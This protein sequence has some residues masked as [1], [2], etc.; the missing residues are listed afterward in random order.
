MAQAG[1]PPGALLACHTRIHKVAFTES[2]GTGKRTQEM[3]ARSNLKQV[4]LELGEGCWV[5]L[6]DCLFL[7]F[8]RSMSTSKESPDKKDRTEMESVQ[9]ICTFY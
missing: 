8:L 9:T 2:V 7:R 6:I 3:A 1:F 4:T 5:S